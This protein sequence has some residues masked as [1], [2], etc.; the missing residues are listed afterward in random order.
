VNLAEFPANMTENDRIIY[1]PIAFKGNTVY[2]YETSNEKLTP[3]QL[4]TL[5][6][7]LVDEDVQAQKT[8]SKIRLKE[9][10]RELD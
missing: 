5:I 7:S 10:R 9:K 3:E 6:M 4:I 1:K 2:I 8:E